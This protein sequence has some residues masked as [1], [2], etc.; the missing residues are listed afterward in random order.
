MILPSSTFVTA[1]VGDEL[2]L[3][4]KILD[5]NAWAATR[6]EAGDWSGAIGDV[7]HVIGATDETVTITVDG[8][9]PI[10]HNTPLPSYEVCPFIRVENG[11]K[12]FR[13]K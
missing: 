3:S 8:P 1:A 11:K 9:R 6:I 13:R 12:V 7:D 2:V 4:V 5:P 10:T